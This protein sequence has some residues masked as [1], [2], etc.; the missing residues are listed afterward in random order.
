M[1]KKVSSADNQQGSLPIRELA[2]WDDP[3]ETTRRAPSMFARRE[4]RIL[5]SIFAF[6]TQKLD[7]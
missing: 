3:S 7:G 4:L 6:A 5:F 2:D 1:S